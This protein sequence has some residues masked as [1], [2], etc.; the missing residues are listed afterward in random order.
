MTT[1]SMRPITRHNKDKV[2]RKDG[3]TGDF[4]VFL[5]LIGFWRSHFSDTAN[6]QQDKHAEEEFKILEW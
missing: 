2:V 4:S 5:L 1:T 6:I 3:H